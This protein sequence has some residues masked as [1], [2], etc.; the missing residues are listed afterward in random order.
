M[1]TKSSTKTKTKPAT[2]KKKTTS[3]KVA[4]KQNLLYIGSSSC[5]WCKK[6]D[7][8]VDELIKDGYKITKLDVTIPDEGKIANDA[9]QKHNAQCGTPLF[10]DEESGNMKCGFAEKDIIE[11]WAKGEEIPAPPRPKTPAPPPPKDFDNTQEVETFKTAY[12]KWVKENDHMPNLMP[13]DQIIERLKAQ[14]AQR[15]QAGPANAPNPNAPAVAPDAS[16]NKNN[17]F[18]YIVEGGQRQ[19]VK[20]EVNYIAGLKQQYYYREQNGQLTKVVGDTTWGTQPAPNTAPPQPNR[21][22]AAQ[23]P[24]GPSKSPGAPPK[25][26]NQVKKKMEASRKANKDKTAEKS[27]SNKKTVKGL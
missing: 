27:K 26:S 8:I 17:D 19:A 13:F 24:T 14:A 3:K 22:N 15:A 9:K 25:V 20:A 23:A 7:P 5:G 4:T 11:K 21:P 18:Y 10:L 6:A 2:T 16:I 12:E 1:A